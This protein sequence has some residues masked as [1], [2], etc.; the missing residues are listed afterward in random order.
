VK[1]DLVLKSHQELRLGRGFFTEVE[2]WWLTLT[3][4]DL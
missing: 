4:R 2:V 1:S 3:D